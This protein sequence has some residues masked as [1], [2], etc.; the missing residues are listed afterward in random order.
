MVGV[1]MAILF[2]TVFRKESGKRDLEKDLDK[3][4]WRPLGKIGEEIWREW[5]TLKAAALADERRREE[6]GKGNPR[7]AWAREKQMG[8]ESQITEE[9]EELWS[10]GREMS[11]VSIGGSKEKVSS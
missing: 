6:E 8:G 11:G 1:R 9:R 5:K 4:D 2:L 10:L 3:L 7:A